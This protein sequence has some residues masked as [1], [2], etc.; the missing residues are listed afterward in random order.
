MLAEGAGAALF[1]GACV[2]LDP[3]DASLIDVMTLGGGIGGIGGMVCKDWVVAG[4]E[5]AR[6]SLLG[7]ETGLTDKSL[8]GVLVADPFGTLLVCPRVMRVYSASSPSLS[9][10]ICIGRLPREYLA[11]TF[12]LI[13]SA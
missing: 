6:S 4:M 2:I 9:Y 1:L 5:G 3:G 10:D 8:A 13:A 11:V 12:V 7:L